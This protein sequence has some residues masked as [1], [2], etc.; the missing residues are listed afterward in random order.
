[1]T[2]QLCRGKYQ[3]SH[4]PGTILIVATGWHSTGGYSVWFEPERAPFHVALYHEAPNIG[5]DVLI[6]FTVATTISDP[7]NSIQV[8]WVHD[9]AGNHAVKVEP[10]FDLAE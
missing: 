6:A 7:T 9:A 4:V 10:A 3:A 8:V 5:T 1:M 2:K